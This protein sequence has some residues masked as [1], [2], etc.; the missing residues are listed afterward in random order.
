MKVY[1]DYVKWN[2][3]RIIENDPSQADDIIEDIVVITR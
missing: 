2:V 1:K 3:N